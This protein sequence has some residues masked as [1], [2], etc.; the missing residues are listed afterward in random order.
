MRAITTNDEISYDETWKII[1]DAQRV[2]ETWLRMKKQILQ[3]ISI[4]DEQDTALCMPMGLDYSKPNIQTSQNIDNVHNIYERISSLRLREKRENYVS[5]LSQFDAQLN[6]LERV[7]FICRQMSLYYP[8]HA[9][10]V[11]MLY[12]TGGNTVSDA[13]QKLKKTKATIIEMRNNTIQAI[14]NI[15][16]YSIENCEIIGLDSNNI[17]EVIGS[18]LT[19]TINKNEKV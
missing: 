13:A 9:R 3:E 4:I 11:D 8:D 2:K 15:Y 16:N 18:E 10:V 6:K 1:K 12:I 14:T 17:G 7:L 19:E 5:Q